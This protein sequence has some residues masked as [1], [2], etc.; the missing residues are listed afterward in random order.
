MNYELK[1]RK[2]RG[3]RSERKDEGVYLRRIEKLTEALLSATFGSA[4]GEWR[5][6][7]EDFSAS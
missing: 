5:S 2:Q 3:S 7:G 6:G 4:E 1:T